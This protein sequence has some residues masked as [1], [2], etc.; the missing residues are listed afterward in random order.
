M[1][2]IAIRGGGRRDESLIAALRFRRLLQVHVKAM[3]Y[4]ISSNPGFPVSG[5]AVFDLEPRQQ[6]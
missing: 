1:Q 2:G 4:A 6:H 3:P 5:G